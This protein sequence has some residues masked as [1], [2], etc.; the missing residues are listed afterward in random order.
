[1]AISFPH[2]Y[3]TL[4]WMCAPGC[5]HALGSS[6]GLEQASGDSRFA[7]QGQTAWLRAL[8]L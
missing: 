5:D 7:N 8:D 1:M 2:A 3:I 4:H 6:L